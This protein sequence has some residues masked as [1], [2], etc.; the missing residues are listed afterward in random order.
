MPGASGD[1]H[2]DMEHILT[3]FVRWSVLFG[4][5]TL[6]IRPVGREVGVGWSRDVDISGFVVCY[7]ATEKCLRPGFFRHLI[8]V[9]GLLWIEVECY[10]L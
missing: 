5:S 4:P 9:K 3:C 6:H 8:S 1:V 10:P 7:T 2:I